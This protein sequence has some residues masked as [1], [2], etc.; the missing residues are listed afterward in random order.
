MLLAPGPS[1]AT[2]LFDALVYAASLLSHT[3]DPQT[4]PVIILFSDGEDTFSRNPGKNVI[5][6]ALA[7]EVQIYCVNLNPHN[8]ANGSR[9]LQAIAEATGGQYFQMSEGSL[10]MLQAVLDDLHNG[11]LVTY[12]VPDRRAGFHAVQILPTHNLNLQFRSRR[13]YYYPGAAQ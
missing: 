9:V 3:R 7:G 6:A 5:E 2:P 13:G 8:R 1:G 10:P 11:Y 4:R 12:K